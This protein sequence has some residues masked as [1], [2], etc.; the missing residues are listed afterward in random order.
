[1]VW[2]RAK[3]RWLSWMTP[4][5]MLIGIGMSSMPI[6]LMA[7]IVGVTQPAYVLD[8]IDNDD[9]RK[10]HEGHDHGTS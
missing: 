5:L 3:C 4:I 10:A 7:G 1:M 6:W 9:Q 8:S 2:L